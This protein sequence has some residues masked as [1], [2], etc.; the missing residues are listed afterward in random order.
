MFLRSFLFLSIVS[1]FIGYKTLETC[2]DELIKENQLLRAEIAKLKKETDYNKV[3]AVLEVS[4]MNIVYRGIFNPIKIAMPRAIKIEA[5]AKGLRKV[6]G[7]GN[8]E[9]AP[10]VGKTITID[11]KG[12]MRNGKVINDTKTLR[13]KN[14]GTVKTLFQGREGFRNKLKLTK[15]DLKKGKLTLKIDDF[16]Y[17]NPMEVKRFK[18]KL[19][20]NNTIQIEGNKLN[21]AIRK[22]VNALKRGDKVQIFDIQMKYEGLRACKITPITIQITD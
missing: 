6:D 1:L 15:E 16:L 10:G 8:Y 21:N 18:I 22:L 12:T 14:I 5:N 9:L 7:F 2:K 20:K 19:H 11:V 13:I 17:D 3:E 4:K